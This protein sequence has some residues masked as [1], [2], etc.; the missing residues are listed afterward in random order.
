MIGIIGAGISGLSLAYHLQKLDIPYILL[1]AS[2]QAGGYIRTIQDNSTNHRAYVLEQ[3]PNS[4]MVDSEIQQIIEELG[5]D[6]ELL[7]SNDV[8]QNRYIFKNGKYRKLPAKPSKLLFNRFFSFSS[9]LAIFKE[10]RRP[11][12]TIENETLSQFFERRFSKEIV[13]Y[14]L[15]PFVAGIYAGDPEQLLMHKTFAQLHEYEQNYGSV[16]KGLIKNKSVERRHTSSFKKGMQTLPKAFAQKLDRLKLSLQVTNVQKTTSGYT[17]HTNDEQTF[18]VNQ[19]VVATAAPAAQQFLAESFPAFSQALGKIYYPPMVAVHSTYKRDAIKHPLDGFGGLNP[20]IEGLYTAGSI[21]TSSI[22][23]GRCPEDEVLFTTFV[24]GTQSPQHTTNSKQIT[25][26]KV[27]QELS[28]HYQISAS[29]LYQNL[30]KWDQ[31]IPQ[32]DLNILDAHRIAD[33]L[34]QE[35]LFVCANWKDGISLPDCIKK[36]KKLATKLAEKYSPKVV[37]E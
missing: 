11:K 29:P 33:E 36:G 26:G 25:L 8:S 27:H 3:G 37:N 17:I 14:A 4:I 2:E 22:F 13:D 16:I 32:Y 6:E 35:Q 23:S 7:P 21:W 19:L 20:K 15:N 31:A 34:E 24:G 18:Q 12:Q 9:K 10:R 1:E 28:E 30:C 5:I